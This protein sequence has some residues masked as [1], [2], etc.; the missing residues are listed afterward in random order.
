MSKILDRIGT[1]KTSRTSQSTKSTGQKATLNVRGH[2]I[3]IHYVVFTPK[4]VQKPNKK[5]NQ[6][7]GWSFSY[8][9][10]YHYDQ[11]PYK[12]QQ[13]AINAAEEYLS[14]ILLPQL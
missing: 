1:Y 12:S 14:T 2:N 3:F 7:W 4:Y 10:W 13:D 5:D 9:N 6:Y 8:E 11:G